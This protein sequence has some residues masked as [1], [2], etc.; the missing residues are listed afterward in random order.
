LTYA[1]AANWLHLS[2][3]P[4]RR[5]SPVPSQV[6]GRGPQGSSNPN[7]IRAPRAQP[8]WVR[9]VEDQLASQR[10][11]DLH[12]LLLE[13]GIALA[14]LV[15]LSLA[16]GWWAAGR[17]LRPLRTM[18]ES[19]RRISEDNLG[20]RLAH[21]GPQDELKDLADTLDGLFARLDAAFE[22]QRSFVANASHEL[23]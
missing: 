9:A 17:V 5:P 19:A 14:A 16:L 3:F 1:L 12:Q 20:A 13:L 15:L 18:T 11:A 4:L 23:R 7:D 10:T 21:A 8:P 6:F 22:A 2:G